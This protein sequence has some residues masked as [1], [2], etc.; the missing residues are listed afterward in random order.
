MELKHLRQIRK[1][2]AHNFSYEM[3]F[4]QIRKEREATLSTS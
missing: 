3:Q 2:T 1:R 4:M